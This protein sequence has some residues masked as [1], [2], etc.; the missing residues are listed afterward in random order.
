ML[1]RLLFYSGIMCALKLDYHA[2][3]ACFIYRSFLYESILRAQDRLIFVF[4]KQ[5]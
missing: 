2:F 1:I 4:S 3:G 5:K